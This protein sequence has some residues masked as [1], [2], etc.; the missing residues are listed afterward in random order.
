[1]L[2]AWR[3]PVRV[4]DEVEFFNL[5]NPSSS[6]MALGSTQHITKMST[7]KFLGV[8]SGRRVGLTTLTPS[9]IRM[10]KNV[11]AS[12]YR[13]PKG[14][15]GLYRD[16]FNFFLPF[17]FRAHKSNEHT[18]RNNPFMSNQIVIFMKLSQYIFCL[19]RKL[20]LIR[21]LFALP[22]I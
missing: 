10:S 14:L 17:T 7:R 5:P 20:Q 18:I 15:H 9:M 3:S 22:L 21:P 16:N 13:N 4:P 12:T 8:K 11:G 19:D 2:Q 1:M 6:I